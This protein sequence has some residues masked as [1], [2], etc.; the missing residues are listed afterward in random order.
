MKSPFLTLAV[1]VSLCVLAILVCGYFGSVGVFIRPRAQAAAAGG[2]EPFVTLRAENG[3]VRYLSQ[4]L[5]SS[6]AARLSPGRVYP[7]IDFLPFRSPDLRR[8]IWEF[9]AHSL[10][11]GS[12]PS[13]WLAACPI[14]CI[15]LPFLIAPL[16]RLRK[17][18][19]R[20]PDPAGF[21]VIEPSNRGPSIAGVTQPPSAI[22]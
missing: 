4:R 20:R 18:R 16:L 13:A 2:K 3:R 5:A 1:V 15:A 14:W 8:S 11:L 21:S 7:S 22:V 12:S 6:T 19:K 9:D 10:N 17:W